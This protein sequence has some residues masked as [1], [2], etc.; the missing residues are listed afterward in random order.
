MRYVALSSLFALFVSA[1]C[2]T[3]A[4]PPQPVMV[5]PARVVAYYGNEH[6]IPDAFGGGWCYLDGQHEHDYY[7]DQPANYVVSGGFYYWN[8]PVGF[9][10]YSGH[11]LPGGGWCY[12]NG[13]HSH[14]YYPPQSEGWVYRPGS[15]YVYAGPYRAD[16]PPPAEYWAHPA[17]PVA[18][19][20]GA[21][22]APIH[23]VAS[24]APGNYHP[25]SSHSSQGIAPAS[26][27][28]H[29]SVAPAGEHE[30]AAGEPERV[31][32]ST[33]GVTAEHP[34]HVAGNPSVRAQP[35]ATP[36][37]APPPA[38]PPPGK[39]AVAPTPSKKKKT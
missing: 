20:P 5:A 18:P 2:T 22:A 25:V 28:G 30:R 24:A 32:S 31:G 14:G 7:P 6:A 34:D 19:P 35:A 37:A 17:T 29:P 33:P 12:I 13:P 3:R 27:G 36:A 21:G 10:Y 15:G 26:A 8:A 16:S 38:A 11:P 4:P 39:K 9:T 23:P 1:C